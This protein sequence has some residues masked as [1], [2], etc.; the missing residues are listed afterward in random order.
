MGKSAYMQNVLVRNGTCIVDP[1]IVHS[2]AV[3]AVS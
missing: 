1:V 2:A 3:F